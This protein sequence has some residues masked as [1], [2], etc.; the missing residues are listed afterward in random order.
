MKPKTRTRMLWTMAAIV[1]TY[2][3]LNV[4]VYFVSGS[5]GV[6]WFVTSLL[7]YGIVLAAAI[8]LLVTDRE[9]APEPKPEAD[10]MPTVTIVAQAPPRSHNAPVIE[11]MPVPVDA[12][13]DA[14]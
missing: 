10:A 1:I 5:Y 3:L 9:T 7:L 14:E 11:T 6:G 2:A 12:P 8:I 13:R 4:I